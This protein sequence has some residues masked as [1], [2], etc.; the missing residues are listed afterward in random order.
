[1]TVPLLA[2]PEVSVPATKTYTASLQALVDLAVV[3]GARSLTDDLARLPELVEACVARSFE[4][5]PELVGSLDLMSDR[6]VLT[7]VGQRTGQA[8]AAEI[9]LKIREVAGWPAEA[10][11]VPDLVH[12]PVAALSEASV[13]W[14]VETG[15]GRGYW[16]TVRERL[17]RTGARIVAVAPGPAG[18]ST[19]PL[20]DGLPTWLLDL[21]AV[22]PGQVAALLLGRAAG[23]DVDRP[24]GLSKV[25]TAP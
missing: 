3:G 5:V 24:G 25:T 15:G 10:L 1:M 21:V 11:S 23:R 14:L 6:G 19:V 22:V 17:Q 16:S 12:G 13:V 18:P 8:T 7:V 20:P 2:G 9:A 4:C